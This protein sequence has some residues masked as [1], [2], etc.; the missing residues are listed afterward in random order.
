MKG[1]YKSETL[2]RPVNEPNGMEGYGSQASRW[3]RTHQCV[4]VGCVR[5]SGDDDDDGLAQRAR[6]F[7]FCSSNIRVRKADCPMLV[8]EA[9]SKLL[10]Y[11]S[12]GES[13]RW[14]GQRAQIPS[15]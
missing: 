5:Y 11:S 7:W 2:V 8:S 6:C 3:S 15:G 12:G 10:E 1:I 13:G 4:S 14:C 9:G